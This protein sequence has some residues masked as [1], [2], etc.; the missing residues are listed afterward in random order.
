MAW[1]S[2]LKLRGGSP[3]GVLAI[4]AAIKPLGH[5][6]LGLVGIVGRVGDLGQHVEAREQPRTLVIAQVADV[7]DA[8][9]AE[10][11][12]DQQR[13]QRLQRRDLLRAGQ[14]RMAD[15]LRQ[16]EVQQ[17]G[18]EEEEAG[19]LGRELASVVE[20]QPPDV[21]DVGDY[22][23]VVGVLAR[24]RCRTTLP[25]RGQAGAA[26]EAEEIRFADVE[27]LSLQPARMSA[28]VAP[29]RRSSQA[30]SWIASRFGDVLGPGLAAAKSDVDVG[31]ASEVA[32][33]GSNRTGSE[34]ETA[35]RSHRRVRIRRSRR[36]RSRSDA[37][38]VNRAAWNRRAS[39]WERA[40]GVGSQLGKLPA[41][42][43][44]PGSPLVP[45]VAEGDRGREARNEGGSAGSTLKG[46]RR[47]SGAGGQNR[48]TTCL[49]RHPHH[50]AQRPKKPGKTGRSAARI[51]CELGK[52]SGPRKSAITAPSTS[53]SRNAVANGG[54]PK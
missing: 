34:D 45:G 16:V 52:L 19:D 21:G 54:S 12:G 5:G 31:V 35:W 29:W 8:P 22:G 27:P 44:H 4:T 11:L 13:E 37:G 48:G 42:E 36:G 6:P 39:S 20:D 30:R 14:L 46:S 15:G 26:Q 2:R 51:G 49:N 38:P 23:T 53:R 24:L 47:K 1:K 25:R 10:E 28:K 17:Q 43:G 3:N 32:D 41:P 40:I 18:K 9:L 50:G 33:D 7:T